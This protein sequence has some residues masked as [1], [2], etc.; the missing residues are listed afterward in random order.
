[1]ETARDKFAP[2]VRSCMAENLVGGI[3]FAVDASLIQ[4]DADKQRSVPGVEWNEMDRSANAGQAV[5]DYL[6]TLDDAAFGAASPIVPKFIS[7]SDPASQWIGA[8]R[9]QALFAY[10]DNYLID[11]A[12]AAISELEA[13]A[14]I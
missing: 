6:S 7:P 5:R 2:A 1:M 3:S 13:L 4:A 9:G 14:V 11:T 10:A 8:H 12:T